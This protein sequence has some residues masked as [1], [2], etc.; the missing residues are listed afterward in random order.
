MPNMSK[1][2][3]SP[4]YPFHT[5][6]SMPITWTI[7]GSDSGGGAGIQADLKVMNQLQTHVCSIITAIT[8]QNTQ[9]VLSYQ[10]VSS[11]MITAQGEALLEDL[12]P[13]ALKI[14]MIGD[15]PTLEAV[16]SI[17]KALKASR[18]EKPSPFIICDPVLIA[19]SGDSLS[20]P[21]LAKAIREKLFPFV[22]LITP[23]RHEAAVLLGETPNEGL[24]AET[25]VDYASRLRTLG[26]PN[27]MIKGGSNTEK[28]AS[29]YFSGST[30]F[31]IHSP[32]QNTRSTHGTGCT[33]SAAITAF[34]AHQETLEDAV[35]AAK[36]YINQGLSFAPILEQDSDKQTRSTGH[37]PLAH[38]A[39]PVDSITLN[40]ETHGMSDA[41][42][43]PANLFPTVSISN[44]SQPNTCFAGL[45]PEPLGFYPVVPNVEWVERLV[46]LGVNTLQLR[47]KQ[48]EK[49]S[50]D[51]IEAQVKRAVEITRNTTCRLFINDHW[52]L[53]LQY[54]A[55][56]VHLGHQD[57]PDAD[58]EALKNAGLRLGI[59]THCYK[60]LALALG[61]QPSYVAFGPVYAT[62]TKTMTF[63][64]QGLN[65]LRH[66]RSITSPPL[67]AI[68]GIFLDENAEEV[69]NTGVDGL[70]VVRDI[71][72]H[73]DPESQTLRWLDF[74]R[75]S[76]K[77]SDALCTLPSLVL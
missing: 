9:Q 26:V 34:I 25:V 21:S 68:G 64:P 16:I 33:L 45:G 6:T 61:H 11:D 38:L 48:S 15:V 7:A 70:A 55:Y 35:V 22:D 39:W 24:S 8:A 13:K 56:G 74:M 71:T 19:T 66:W 43:T 67:V 62:T 65:K 75:G 23:N 63:S 58:L 29:D 37:G 72:E 54:G 36:A 4:V 73:S 49:T 20:D 17:L 77:N 28:L 52:E 53:A 57:L 51:A 44:I 60:E 27:V 2:I 1:T 41:P 40:H 50:W 42:I 3:V 47:L 76:G 69:L 59:S 10:S 30:S 31:W 12:F 46:P 14:G 5:T 18:N 32:T